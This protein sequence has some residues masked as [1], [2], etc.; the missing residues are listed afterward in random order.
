MKGYRYV[1]MFVL[2]AALGGGLAWLRVAPA[3]AA[4]LLAVTL[5]PTT[6]PTATSTTEPTPTSTTEPT[7]TPTTPPPSATPTATEPVGPPPPTPTA[8]SPGDP[9]PTPTDIVFPPPGTPSVTPQDPGDPRPTRTPGAVILPD[10]GE[11]GPSPLDGLPTWVLPGL[12]FTGAAIA[13]ALT[14]RRIR[15]SRGQRS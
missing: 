11:Q 12:A 7:Q 10:T 15:R 6:E 13:G 3:A 1:L 5:T 9:S 8:T 14:G 4:N 2:I